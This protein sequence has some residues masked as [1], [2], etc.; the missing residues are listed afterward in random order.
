MTLMRLLTSCDLSH[1]F[2]HSTVQSC[3]RRPFWTSRWANYGPGV[4]M[5]PYVVSWSSNSCISSIISVHCGAAKHTD[6]VATLLWFVFNGQPP[7]QQLQRAAEATRW[8]W[9]VGAEQIVADHVVC[10]YV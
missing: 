9:R 2:V 5:C 1:V 10:G 4:R 6:L 8:Q 7:P 3:R